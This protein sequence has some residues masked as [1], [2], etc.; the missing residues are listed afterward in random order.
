MAYRE[1]A[2]HTSSTTIRAT[3]L[4]P[5]I[6]SRIESDIATLLS[7]K[8]AEEIRALLASRVV[9]LFPEINMTDEQQIAF[10]RTLGT[11]AEENNGYAGPDGRPQSIYKVDAAQT[12]EHAIRRLRNNFLW[13][14]E[15][16]PIELIHGD[17]LAPGNLIQHVGWNRRPA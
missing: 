16:N 11:L 12:D 15:H 14:L 5:F 10:T 1:S 7:G 3:N 2:M 9:L 17:S 4:A 8:I 6:G 13:H